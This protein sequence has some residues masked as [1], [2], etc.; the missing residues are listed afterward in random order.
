MTMREVRFKD[1]RPEHEVVMIVKP[2]RYRNALA[3]IT[4]TTRDVGEA[5]IHLTEQQVIALFVT[6]QHLCETIDKGGN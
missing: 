3:Q 1:C 2:E 5:T 6:L 4:V